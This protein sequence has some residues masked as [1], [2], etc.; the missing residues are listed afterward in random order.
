MFVYISEPVYSAL[1]T[2]TPGKPGYLNTPSPHPCQL[3]CRL[4]VM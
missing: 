1:W 4:P 3:F 2:C